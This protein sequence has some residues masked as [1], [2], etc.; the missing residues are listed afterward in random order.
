MYLLSPD[1]LL[2]INLQFFRLSIKSGGCHLS[3]YEIRG[4]GKQTVTL[5][6]RRSIL[7]KFQTESILVAQLEQN[8]PVGRTFFSF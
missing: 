7:Q 1:V 2:G 8:P 3:E 4:I 5:E 6:K